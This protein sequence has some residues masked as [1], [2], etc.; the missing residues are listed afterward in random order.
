MDKFE[1]LNFWGHSPALNL[2]SN[3]K[4]K[5]D[6]DDSV[7]ILVVG[8]GDCRHVLLTI[9][10]N[11]HKNINF[12]IVDKS[13]ELYARQMLLLALILK[14]QSKIGLQDKIEMFLEI[15]GNT[16]I[17]KQTADYVEQLSSQLIKDFRL[18]Q[19][20]GPRYDAI[21]NVFDWHFHMK[22]IDRDAE[23]IG[24]RNY[25]R[26][27]TNGVAYELRDADYDVQNKTLAS[28]IALKKAHTFFISISS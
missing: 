4:I 19:Y 21:P 2:I 13:V 23:V 3:S 7:N 1:Y 11:M 26:W 28:S 17:R 6:G 10:K 18:R 5:K 22:L 15:H 25:T 20:L 16:L 8:G 9:S 14:P 27:R 12:F 24:I